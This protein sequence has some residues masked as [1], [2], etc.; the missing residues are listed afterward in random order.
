MAGSEYGYRFDLP[1]VEVDFGPQARQML[2]EPAFLP[3]GNLAETF[4]SYVLSGNALPT[5]EGLDGK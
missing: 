2:G 4:L 1:V 3:M 5:A